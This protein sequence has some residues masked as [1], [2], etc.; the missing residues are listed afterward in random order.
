[1]ATQMITLKLE[2]SF[3]KNIDNIVQ[4]RGY[5]SRTEFIRNALRDKIDEEKYKE[6][7]AS[8]RPVYGAGRKAIQTSD[9]ELE[10]IREK[11]AK[12][13]LLSKKESDKL[14]RSIGL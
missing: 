4:R 10:R 6:A 1:M 11:M 5:Q 14:F 9:E 2:D 8:I 3:L 13:G 12:S 7:A